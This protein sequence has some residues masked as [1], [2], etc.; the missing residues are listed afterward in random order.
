M[1]D[2]TEPQTLDEVMDQAMD[3]TPVEEPKVET[4]TS[5]ETA[6]PKTEEEESYTRIDPKTLPP[7]LQALHKSLLRDY[8]KKT[9]SIAQQRKEYE[10]WKASQSQVVPTAKEEPQEVPNP[11]VRPDMSLDEY[12][13]FMMA[14][15]EEKLTLQQQKAIEEQQNKYLEEAVLEVRSTDERMNPESPAY[16]EFMHHVVGTKLDEALHKFT[17]EN[18]S[19]M[20]FDVK[21]NLKSLIQQ[22]EQY[23]ETKAKELA[24]LKTKEAFSGVKRNA[25][26]GISGSTA[27]SKPAGGM[28]LDEALDNAFSQ[29]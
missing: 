7:E 28:S 26:M 23:T 20:G 18:G 25:P 22:Y 21:S 6:E 3:P 11:Q 29:K 14:Q 24:A 5:N 4:P 12:T 9:Q 10:A 19:V 27:P 8:T 15:M 16:D 13:K 17:E 1:P 2:K